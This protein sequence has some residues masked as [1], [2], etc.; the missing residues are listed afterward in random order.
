MTQLSQCLSMEYTIFPGSSNEVENGTQNASNETT[1]C[2][3]LGDAY[4]I[5]IFW[6]AVAELPGMLHVHVYMHTLLFQHF[7]TLYI[8]FD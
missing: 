5:K 2:N 6:T 8:D 1:E 3:G 7:W 4:Y